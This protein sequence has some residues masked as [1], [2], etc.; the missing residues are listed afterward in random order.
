MGGKGR[1]YFRTGGWV[2][3]GRLAA[4]VRRQKQLKGVT[5]TELARRSGLSISTVSA[6]VRGNRIPSWGSLLDLADALDMPVADL[7]T[8]EGREAIVSPLK[9]DGSRV[10]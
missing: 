5:Q 3:Q 2:D 6:Y 4:E 10:A 7:L 9:G 8:D 1:G